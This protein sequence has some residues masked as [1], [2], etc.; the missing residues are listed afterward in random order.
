MTADSLVYVALGLTA[1]IA[2]PISQ[3]ATPRAL[4]VGGGGTLVLSGANTYTG[5]TIINSGI[6][7]AGPGQADAFGS[8]R[9]IAF[10]AGSTGKLQLNGQ[11]MTIY[12]AEHQRHGRHADRRKRQHYRWHR[13]S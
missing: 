4:I 1:T 13:Y 11:D 10:G 7:Q 12:C 9:S 8:A 6:L 3:D 5:A 2:T